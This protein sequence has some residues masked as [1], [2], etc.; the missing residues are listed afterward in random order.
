[1]ELKTSEF[2]KHLIKSE[3]H[4]RI[5]TSFANIEVAFVLAGVSFVLSEGLNGVNR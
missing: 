3:N 1:M 5:L 2:Q 4:F